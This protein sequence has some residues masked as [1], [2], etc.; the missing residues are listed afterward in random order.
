MLLCRS[1]I[2]RHE[3]RSELVDDTECYNISNAVVKI[4][5]RDAGYGGEPP[6]KYGVFP[7]TDLEFPA[8]KEEFKK[9]LSSIED[10]SKSYTPTLLRLMQVDHIFECTRKYESYKDASINF[11]YQSVTTNI[12][13][14]KRYLEREYVKEWCD[15]F[16]IMMMLRYASSLTNNAENVTEYFFNGSGKS[17]HD[18]EKKYFKTLKIYDTLKRYKTTNCEIFDAILESDLFN[19]FL[20]RNRFVVI[21]DR[22]ER[23]KE[24][25]RS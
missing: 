18:D 7:E 2:L 15:L 13:V 16:I 3:E 21:E 24:R 11:A 5:Y 8:Q 19:L 20:I 6:N 25:S 22:M 12:N 14:W 17:V 23:F 10:L 9:I 4:A 1:V